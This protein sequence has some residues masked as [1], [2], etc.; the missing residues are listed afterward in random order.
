MAESISKSVLVAGEGQPVRVTDAVHITCA[1]LL[2]DGT[3]VYT[4]ENKPGGIL[5]VDLSANNALLP[6]GL[7]DALRSSS[8]R[9]GDE[10]ELKVP[11]ALA[12]GA[13]GCSS[14]QSAIPPNSDLLYRVKVVDARTASSVSAEGAAELAASTGKDWGQEASRHKEEGNKLLQSNSIAGAVAAYKQS[15]SC[16]RM[17]QRQGSASTGSGAGDR[18]G[19]V[20]LQALHAAVHSNLALAYL[21]QGKPALAVE[22]A[23]AVLSHEEQHEK[24]LFRRAKG[25]QG[26][27]RQGEAKETIVKL[28]GVNPANID[29][30]ALQAELEGRAAP[31]QKASTGQSGVAVPGSVDTNASSAAATTSAQPQQDNFSATGSS[32]SPAER[33]SAAR[34]RK[35]R[36]DPL[37]SAAK[38][39]FTSTEGGL[40]QD[41]PGYEMPLPDIRPHVHWTT[42]LWEGVRD[43]T[44]AVTCGLCCRRPKGKSA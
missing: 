44:H 35:A 32:S 20:D 16:I 11:A 18:R 12:Y 27:G 19:A 7:A 40:Y 14:F 2:T 9:V 21:K 15:A 37:A 24:A 33:A 26:L 25:L 36:E 41:T 13:E 6:R 30:L 28:L 39:M 38:R 10:C 4:S 42:W 1:C 22:A 17:A 43:T 31:A 29:A 8:L 5:E 3:I 23:D 34:Q